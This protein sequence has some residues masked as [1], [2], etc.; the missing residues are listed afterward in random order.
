MSIARKIARKQAWQDLPSEARR[1]KNRHK[2][3]DVYGSAR[4]LS[5]RC[6]MKEAFH[7]N[8]EAGLSS[9]KIIHAQSGEHM[10]DTM[11]RILPD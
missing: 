11:A 7:K 9:G 5:R 6:F 8:N 10:Y 1:R 4:H 3:F 2:D